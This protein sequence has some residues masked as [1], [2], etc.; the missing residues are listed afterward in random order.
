[1]RLVDV[2]ALVEKANAPEIVKARRVVSDVLRTAEVVGA[3]EAVQAHDHWLQ[4]TGLLEAM[5]CPKPSSTTVELAFYFSN[6]AHSLI[7]R[8]VTTDEQTLRYLTRANRMAAK[9]RWLIE[10]SGEVRS[11][12]ARAVP[13][14]PRRGRSRRPSCNQRTRGSRRVASRSAG[15][16]SSGDPDS[17]EP[18][19]G[20][21][22]L[23]IHI[24]GRHP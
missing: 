14:A 12:R 13:P 23:G 15:G 20:G 10:A 16:G 7:S 24:H 18:A 5:R 19:G 1:M 11:R 9:A 17:D 6:R 21:H 8:K 4:T 3:S 22:Q 2:L